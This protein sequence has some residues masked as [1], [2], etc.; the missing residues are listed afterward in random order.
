MKRASDQIKIPK[1]QL[2]RDTFRSGGPGGQH[3]NKT[4]SGVRYTH[5]P[6]G[7]AAESRSDRSQN[8]NDEIAYEA[9]CQKLLSLVLVQRFGTAKQAWRDKPEPSFGQQ[10]R[11]YVLAGHRRVVDHETGWSGD[12]NRVLRGEIDELLQLRLAEQAKV[13]GNWVEAA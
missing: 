11:S 4:E 5:I 1:K 7:I 2:R 8:A 13:A 9:L 10:K 3:Q 6:T 12:P